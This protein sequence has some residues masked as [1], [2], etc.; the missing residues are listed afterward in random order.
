M[1]PA[2]PKYALILLER[3]P[4]LDQLPPEI[5]E[6]CAIAVQ[7]WQQIPAERRKAM[8]KAYCLAND[9]ILDPDGAYAAQ[10][11]AAKRGE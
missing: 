5:R 4:G 8:L 11:E 7:A 10:V 2:N 1:L 6:G 3:P 9:P